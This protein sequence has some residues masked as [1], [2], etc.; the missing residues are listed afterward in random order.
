MSD[1]TFE[2]ELI[3]YKLFQIMMHLHV[4]SDSGYQILW[5]NRG[6]LVVMHFNDYGLLK[7]ANSFYSALFFL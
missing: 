7:G 1:G 3:S 6:S 2:V 4:D 5:F